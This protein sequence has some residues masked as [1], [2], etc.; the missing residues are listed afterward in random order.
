MGAGL[1]HA[2]IAFQKLVI[3]EAE[4]GDAIATL[5][6]VLAQ[7]RPKPLRALPEFAVGELSFAR[8]DSNLVG[9]QIHGAVETPD[10]CQRN[11]HGG[12][13][14]LLVVRA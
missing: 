8:N 2:V 13:V 3:V 11:K 9:K 1:H 12:I 6:S 7:R 10:G 14:L 4:I 5:N